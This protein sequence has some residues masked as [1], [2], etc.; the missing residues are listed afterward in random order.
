MNDLVFIFILVEF[1]PAGRVIGDAELHLIFKVEIALIRIL[2]FETHHLIKQQFS[3]LLF[4]SSIPIHFHVD[5]RL[6]N[7]ILGTML[8]ERHL[9][10]YNFLLD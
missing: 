3:D 1:D 5:I 8:E 7:L 9:V 2:L 4:R 10:G 6:R